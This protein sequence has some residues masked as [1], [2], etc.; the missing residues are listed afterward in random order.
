MPEEKAKGAE[1]E[2]DP[3]TQDAIN[4]L[5][6]E[7]GQMTKE[8]T[9]G[10]PE[11]QEETPEETEQPEPEEPKKQEAKKPQEPK[12]DNKDEDIPADFTDK[13]RSAWLRIRD[14]DKKRKAKEDELRTNT[15]RV[16]RMM[17]EIEDERRKFQQWRDDM[18]RDPVK[19]L[20]ALGIRWDDAVKRTLEDGK[21]GPDELIRRHNESL[22]AEIQQL[23]DTIVKLN[24]K[25]EA[26]GQEKELQSYKEK[27]ANV[28]KDER[29]GLIEL[30]HDDPVQYVIDKA[31]EYVRDTDRLITVDEACEIAL[32]AATQRWQ[33]LKSNKALRN[34]FGLENSEQSEDQSDKRPPRQAVK[35]KPRSLTNA[36]PGRPSGFDPNKI[37]SVDEELRA[38]AKLVGP[39]A[40]T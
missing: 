8:E 3:G 38:A 19:G 39:D 4:R 37:G 40:W 32:D 36:V 25:F 11:P 6:I 24:Q 9:D 30:E 20:E 23:K 31:G 35:P 1:P 34:L 16:N 21:P 13:Q 22:T 15:E 27:V 29:F 33:R 26:Y 14:E 2:V 28:L 10:Q 5:L 17:A 7:G 18:Q 12:E